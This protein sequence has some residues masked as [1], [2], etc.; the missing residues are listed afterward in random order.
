MDREFS[1]ALDHAHHAIISRLYCDRDIKMDALQKLKKEI[2]DIRDESIKD[3][4][5]LSNLDSSDQEWDVIQRRLKKS[6]TTANLIVSKKDA[7][8]ASLLALYAKIEHFA[9]FASLMKSEIA[10]DH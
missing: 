8:M 9:E 2:Q 5:T 1:N 4:T 6:G 10:F 7:I 3:L